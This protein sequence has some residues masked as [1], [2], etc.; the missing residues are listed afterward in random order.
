MSEEA[1]NPPEIHL[2]SKLVGGVYASGAVVW[3][4]QHEFT[5]DFLAPA[6]PGSG[7]VVT[8]RVRVP[9][10]VIFDIA[11]A[12]SENVSQFEDRFGELAKRA[13][14]QNLY[15]PEGWGDPEGGS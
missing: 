13:D 11:R 12:I 3:H 10:H 4:T 15:P 6:G 1:A 2:D 9:T 8:S 14:S 5:L 7:Y